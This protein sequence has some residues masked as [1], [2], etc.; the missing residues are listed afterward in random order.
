M[1]LATL[2]RCAWLALAVCVCTGAFAETTVTFYGGAGQVGGSSA[3]VQGGGTRVLVDCGTDYVDDGTRAA[4]EKPFGFDPK[5][6]TAVVLTH[7]H[8]DHSGRIPQLVRDGFRGDVWTTP[9]TRTIL[10]VVWRSQVAYETDVRREWLWTSRGDGRTFHWRTDCE[11]A[12]KVSSK[13]RRT[14][15]GTRAELETRMKRERGDKFFVSAC[16]TCLDLEVEEVMRRVKA[17]PFG[18]CVPLAPFKAEFRPVRHLPG[19]AAVYFDDGAAKFA[20]SGDLGTRRSRFVGTVDPAE[21]VDCVFVETTYGDRA[22]GGLD[23]T[24]AEYRRFRETVG[25]AVGSGGVAWIPAFALDRSQRV[26][27]EIARGIGEGVIDGNVPVYCLSPS[28]RAITEDYLNHLEW[29]DTAE[30]AMIAPVYRRS[31]KRFDVQKQKGAAIL[32]TTSGMMD[33]GISYRLIPDLVPRPDVTLCLVGYQSPSTCGG[34]LRRG[35][36][37]LKTE[38]DGKLRDVPVRCAVESFGCF[39]GHADAKESDAWLAKNL[40]SR[41]F[42]VHGDPESL[43]AR[44]SGLEKRFGASVEIVRPGVAYVM[45]PD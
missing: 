34:R 36:R 33:V 10:G 29:F 26:L 22:R 25:R 1:R 41:I 45:R 14:F 28:S 39:S 40:K 31:R 5:T 35:D 8:Q 42:L 38:V 23:E 21:K 12:R 24:E 7:A 15:T 19:A 32:L 6:L 20:F 44:K 11:W 9:A 4:G 17:V 30:P 2:R 27:A 18:E 13:N 3:L 16:R 43:E 37:V